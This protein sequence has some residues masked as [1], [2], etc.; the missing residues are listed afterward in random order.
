MSNATKSSLG[1]V[2]I[3][4]GF[5]GIITTLMFVCSCI[6]RGIFRKTKKLIA[7]KGNNWKKMKLRCFSLSELEKATKKFSEECL[8]GSGAFGTVYKGVF[9]EACTLAV[10]R[11]HADLYESVDEFRN[12][13]ELLSRVQHENL[14]TLVG[15]CEEA[16]HSKILFH[17]SKTNA[18]RLTIKNTNVGRRGKILTWKE[19][20]NIAIGA[21]K[22]IAYLHEGVRPSIIHRDIKPSNIL[23][24]DGFEAKVSDFGLVKSGP[25]GDEPHVTS[26]IK[27]TPG[28]LDPAYCS[29]SHL[30]TYSDVYSFGVMLLQLV[31]ARPAVVTSGPHSQRHIVDWARPSLQKGTVEEILDAN[32]LLDLEPCNMEMMLKIGQLGLKCVAKEPRD[33]PTMS[34]VVRELEEGMQLSAS[35]RLVGEGEWQS[36]SFN[37]VCLER[38]HL[39]IDELLI[40]S[41]RMRC[42]DVNSYSV[43]IEKLRMVQISEEYDEICETI[44]SH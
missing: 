41:P 18:V 32:L 44:L 37:A 36:C 20:V 1:L 28:Y 30:T 7:F 38:Y 9:D 25:T 27:G 29:S 14:V 21:G 34:Q 10:K 42:L 16:V 31:A 5:A 35:W 8:I 23:V 13:I 12:E 19:R 4:V 17:T 26:Q 22:G 43:D 40:H 24:G 11:L 6:K 39:D 33:R 2:G 15:Y 3:V